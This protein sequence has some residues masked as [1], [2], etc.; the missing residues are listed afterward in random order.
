[1]R[2][3][4]TRAVA[5][6]LSVLAIVL[7]ACGGQGG[8]DSS[9]AGGTPGDGDTGLP[10][11]GSTIKVGST[12]DLAPLDFVDE[13]GEATGFE[14]EVVKAVFDDLG[15]EIEWVK[16][17]FEQAFTGLQT[18]RYRM[19]ASAIYM[20]CARVENTAEYGVFTVPV[21]QAGQAMTTKTDGPDTVSYTHLT[22][23]TNREV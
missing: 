19:N 11:A 22:L 7:A 10:P 2:Y 14:L 18:D 8:A 17:P 16:T 9:P 12:M 13:Q 5:V 23:P 3:S 20:R 4:S 1:M 21:G 15:Y 6:L